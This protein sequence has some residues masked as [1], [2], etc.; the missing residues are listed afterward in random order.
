VHRLKTWRWQKKL[1]SQEATL[2]PLNISS[3]V[4]SLFYETRIVSPQK[5]SVLPEDAIEDTSFMPGFII[6]NFKPGCRVSALHFFSEIAI[7][8]GYLTLSSFR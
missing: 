2:V 6:A 7:T 1:A 4:H 8:N 3:L 5:G